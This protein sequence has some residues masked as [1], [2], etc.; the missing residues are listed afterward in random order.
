MGLEAW[1][2]ILGKRDSVKGVVKTNSRGL[3]VVPKVDLQGIKTNNHR[4]KVRKD[5]LDS[6][7]LRKT[8]RSSLSQNMQT[9]W[10]GARKN[11]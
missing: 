10:H 9:A 11:T 2:S 7:I 3:T 8:T 1:F 6:S 5:V 4:I